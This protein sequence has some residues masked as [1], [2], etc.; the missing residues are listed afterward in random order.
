MEKYLYSNGTFQTELIKGLEP[1]VP[2]LSQRQMFALDEDFKVAL[3]KVG[4]L[5][6][7][8]TSH[9]CFMDADR[10]PVNSWVDC[11]KCSKM[12][13]KVC[14]KHRW[15]ACYKHLDAP[16]GLCAPN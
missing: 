1:L 3:L 2:V 10:W 11:I 6:S 8:E 13:G 9:G 5:E 7:L 12:I 4:C 16:C 14:F 15:M